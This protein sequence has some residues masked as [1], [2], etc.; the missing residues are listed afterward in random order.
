VNHDSSVDIA[1]EAWLRD[2]LDAVPE[3]TAA[4]DRA[5][6]ASAHAGQRMPLVRRLRRMWKG[7]GPDAWTN[8]PLPPPETIIWADP[9]ASRGHASG[10]ASARPS[11]V[12]MLLPAA[13]VAVVLAIA[14]AAA[15][16]FLALGPGSSLF[17]GA[18]PASLDPTAAPALLLQPRVE[19]GRDL[20]VAADGSGHFW[21]LAD[22]VAEAISGDRIRLVPGEYTESVVITEDITIIGS[23]D[24]EAVVLTAAPAEAD[25][26]LTF[27]LRLDGSDASISGLTVRGAEIGTAI[28]VE[29][30][31]PTLDG[32]HIDTA[33]AQAGANPA[34]PKQ[35]I[36]IRSGSSAAVTNSKIS[37]FIEVSGGSRATLANNLVRRG[38][39]RVDGQGTDAQVTEN[40]FE[41]S[42]C[43]GFSITVADGA[44]ADLHHNVI[45]VGVQND[46]IRVAGN[47]T[48]AEISSQVI[49]GGDFGIWLSAGA[50]ATVRRSKITEA[51]TGVGVMGADAVLDSLEVRYNGTG[52]LVDHGAAPNLVGN[53]I[54]ENGT[55]VDIRDAPEFSQAG[56]DV[57]DPCPGDSQ[58]LAAP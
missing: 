4:I 36:A 49:Q 28:I 30:G 21:T 48:T 46:A 7:E 47:G 14:L 17:G 52:L 45:T 40:T 55:N 41:R 51:Q 50:D 53:I 57:T 56:N 10:A 12:G 38:C 37:A 11:G 34:K 58:Q 33:G 1:F 19:S 5:V 54:C 20:I 39:L 26:D 16:L 18:V 8:Q 25:G 32:L 23:D 3:P 35:A 29:G 9:S 43:Y 42:E 22:A 15:S 27:V 2:E 31:A 6:V 44:N 24:R 13:F